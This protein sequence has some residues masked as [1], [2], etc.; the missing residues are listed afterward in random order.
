[1]ATRIVSLILLAV[2][3]TESFAG[4]APSELMRAGE[5]SKQSA[6]DERL[7]D[8]EDDREDNE[9]LFDAPPTLI[10]ASAFNTSCVWN[11]GV[12]IG[13]STR[14]LASPRAPPIV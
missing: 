2:L 11:D 1:M 14:K 13:P 10:F 12:G 8:G 9:E 3:L 4:V 5:E 6:A 7:C